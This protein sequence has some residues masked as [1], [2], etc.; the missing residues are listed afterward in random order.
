MKGK[1][2]GGETIM[3]NVN[4]VMMR[5]IYAGAKRKRKRIM[6]IIK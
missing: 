3:Q 2:S 4:D 6:K 1:G 5:L